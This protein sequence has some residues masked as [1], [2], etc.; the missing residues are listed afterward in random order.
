MQSKNLDELESPL[1]AGHD[2]EAQLLDAD[3]SQLVVRE[4]LGIK[5]IEVDFFKNI[6]IKDVHIFGGTNGKSTYGALTIAIAS[7]GKLIA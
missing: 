5:A 1:K 4:D 7:N 6:G 3:V 2:K